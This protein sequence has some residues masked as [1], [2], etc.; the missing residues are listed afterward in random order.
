M[1][2]WGDVYTDMQCECTGINEAIGSTVHIYDI[3]HSTNMVVRFQTQISH[4]QHA[5]WSNSII[6]KMATNLGI[7]GRYMCIYVPHE[8]CALKPLFC[9]KWY[10]HTDR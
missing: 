7:Y 4:G 3:Y 2:I 8:A 9:T 10:R 1:H 6:N 5:T